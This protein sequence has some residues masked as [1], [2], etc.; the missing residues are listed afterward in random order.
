MKQVLSSN[1]L[2]D[3]EIRSSKDF[4]N[5]TIGFFYRVD[6][7]CA[8]QIEA[9]AKI[10]NSTHHEGLGVG[11]LFGILAGCELL[12]PIQSAVR[13]GFPEINT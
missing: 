5:T 4:L 2:G 6:A 8:N 9:V 13:V 3:L 12:C 1:V 10:N 7:V 11:T